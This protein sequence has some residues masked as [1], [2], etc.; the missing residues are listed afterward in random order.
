[1][2]EPSAILDASILIVDDQEANVMLLEQMLA[3]GGYT[4]VTGTTDPFAV[5]D[6]HQ[7]H[8]FDLILL[9]L[10][11]PGMS[12]FEVLEALKVIEP[13][14]YVPVLVITAQPNHKL[15][16]LQAGAKDFVS[17]PFELIEVE[18][19]I[20]N[21]L[22][23]RLLHRQLNRYN[24]QLEH[25]VMMRTAELRASETRFQR[26]AELSTDWYWEQDAEGTLT[27]WSGPVMDM[28]GIGSADTSGW[29][30]AEHALLKENIDER[31]AF[32]DFVYSRTTPGGAPQF[33]QVSGEPMF[34]EA[35]RFVGYRGVGRDVTAMAAMF[36]KK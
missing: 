17:K 1:M 25:T 28:V 30:V 22:E 31:K 12:G 19:R 13:D 4:N 27:N 26:F 32:L 11:M 36:A 21:M 15:Q 20:R 16:A 6:M 9:D 3:N 35:S 23:V 34:D 2:I 18:T 14:G 33:L 7:E 8:H 10:Q 24:Q 29:D 5:C